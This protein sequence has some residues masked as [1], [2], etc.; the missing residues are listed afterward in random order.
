MPI[1]CAGKAQR[2][3]YASKMASEIRVLEDQLYEAD[4]QNRMLRDQLEATRREIESARIE[5]PKSSAQL[6]SPDVHSPAPPIIQSPVPVDESEVD[7]GNGLESE[8]PLFDAGEIA[9]PDEFAP[10]NRNAGQDEGEDPE[11]LEPSESISTP[12]GSREGD[13]M[14]LPPAPTEPQPPGP[15]DLRSD[16]IVPG[17]VLPPPADGGEDEPGG[18]IEIP[19]DIRTQNT[20]TKLRLHPALSGPL[21]G[22]EKGMIVVVTAT[23]ENGTTIDLEDFDV[24]A[25]LSVV[26]LDPQRDAAA[27]RIGKYDFDADQVRSMVRRR[28]VSGLHLR[29]PP[30]RDDPLGGDVLVHIRLRSGDLEMRCQGTVSMNTAIASAAWTP[31]AK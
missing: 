29:L 4:Y 2:D 3:V 24:V 11:L 7:M 19:K 25:D 5:T 14:T 21:A 30:L 20:P 9:D 31:R 6:F 28:P 15:D 27:A 8:L 1:G 18:R 16:P 13:A 12:P 17:E 22:D 10:P 26:V 23:D